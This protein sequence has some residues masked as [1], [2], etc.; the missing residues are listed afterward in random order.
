M[1]GREG[2]VCFGLDH[3]KGVHWD[4]RECRFGLFWVGSWEGS[5]LGWKGVKGV[6][7]GWEGREYTGWIG[8]K[9]VQVG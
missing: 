9:G 2:L 1:E 7:D 6:Q 8:R 5:T 4:G 3:G